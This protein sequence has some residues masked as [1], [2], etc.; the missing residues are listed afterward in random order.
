MDISEFINKLETEIDTI[1]KGTL[2]PE[3]NY[4]DI[5]GWSSMHALIIIALADTDF[6]VTLT[7]ND[8]R[9]ANTVSD[10]FSIIKARM[11]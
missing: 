2:R 8:L 6:G 1:P 7:G 5:T 9:S 10:L 3:T 4:R 11:A